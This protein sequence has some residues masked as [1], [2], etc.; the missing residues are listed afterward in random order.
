[1]NRNDFVDNIFCKELDTKV[2][3]FMENSNVDGLRNNFTYGYILPEMEYRPD[4]IAAYYMGNSDLAWA[5]MLANDFINGIKDFTLGRKIKI[6]N[7]N[8]ALELKKGE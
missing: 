5:I 6:P 1:M 7:A 2:K 4:K 8:A 3:G